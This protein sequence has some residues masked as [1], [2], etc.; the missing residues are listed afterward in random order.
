MGELEFSPERFC[1]TKTA[2]KAL[3]VDIKSVQRWIKDGSLKAFKLY[4]R[5]L[6]RE[7]DLEEFK[8]KHLIR[9]G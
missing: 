5:F 3:D 7:K 4:G 1:S 2:A 9:A 6:I 8:A